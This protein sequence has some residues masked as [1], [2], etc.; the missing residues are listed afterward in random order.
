MIVCFDCPPETKAILDRLVRTQGYEDLSRAIVSAVENLDVLSR[1]IGGGKSLVVESGGS[2]VSQSPNDTK[3]VLGTGNIAASRGR[4]SLDV[5]GIFTLPRILSHEPAVENPIRER[6]DGGPVPPKQWLFGMYNKLLPLK[7]SC[8]A[9]ANVIV[10]DF[11]QGIPMPEVS[12]V[13]AQIALQAQLLGTSLRGH[14]RVYRLNRDN[15]ISLG[16]PSSAK[17]EKSRQR[18]ASQF[19]ARIMKGT[20]LT[21]F[22]YEYG[23]LGITADR[24]PLVNLTRA[25]WEFAM[26]RNPILDDSQESPSVVLSGEE[27]SFLLEHIRNHVPG[28][29]WLF[30]TILDILSAGARTASEIDDKIAAIFEPKLKVEPSLSTA[31]TGAVSRMMDLGM[32][33]RVR[34]GLSIEYVVLRSYDGDAGEYANS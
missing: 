1:T 27:Q 21:G 4:H 30:S 23:L 25:G 6:L 15:A 8:R 13:A 11:T 7:A 20:S 2:V 18:F 26:L 31:R 32:L 5:P 33:T 24:F 22:P 28:E 19:V 10:N 12:D 14:D 17:D 34:Q 29:W 9:I 3:A 16:F